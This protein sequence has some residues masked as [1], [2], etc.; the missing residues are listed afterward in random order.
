MEEIMR[1]VFACVLFLAA[2][3]LARAEIKLE[4]V[5]YKA[6]DTTLKGFVAYDDAVK[7]KRP[8]VIVVHEWW[9]LT[10][11]AK[12][13]AQKLAELGYVGFAIDMYGDGKTTDD[14]KE[15]GELAGAIKK[16]PAT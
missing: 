1:N 6:G 13:R 14:P 9:G 12:M 11:Y 10:D 15:A 7:E 16:D 2:S 8:A 5:T 3:S 4:P